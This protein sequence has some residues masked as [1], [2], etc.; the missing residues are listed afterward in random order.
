MTDKNLET[1]IASLTGRLAMLETLNAN[2]L[3]Q[4]CVQFDRPVEFAATILD[5]VERQLVSTQERSPEA[6]RIA[7]DT[8]VASFNH[9]SDAM[10]A[11]INRLAEP[12]GNA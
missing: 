7:A 12:S 8:A 5:N 10:L 6:D 11:M 2:F 1:E 9:L 3:A 4:M